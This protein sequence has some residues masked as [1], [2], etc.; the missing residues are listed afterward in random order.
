MWKLFE[1][2][3]VQT[4]FAADGIVLSKTPSRITGTRPAEIDFT[5]CPDLAQTL[6]VTCAMLRVPF[7]FTGLQS[8]RIK[9]TDRIAALKVELAKLGCSVEAGTDYIRSR[10]G[11]GVGSDLHPLIATY[12]D[13]RMAMSFAPCAYVLPGLRIADP[14]VVCKSYPDFWKDLERIGATIDD[15][16]AES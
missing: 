9:E 3:G 12:D 10:S 11:Y 14:A 2:L 7:V 4:T 15:G 5:A 1:P 16:I 6:A 8:L 13:H